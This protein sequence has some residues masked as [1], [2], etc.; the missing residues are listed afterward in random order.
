MRRVLLVFLALLIASLG[1]SIVSAQ[2]PNVQVFFDEYFGATHLE[3][4]PPDAP[5]TVTGYLYVVASNFGMWIS[6]FEYAIDYP[7]Q[8]LPVVDITGGLDIGTSALGIA[9]SWQYPINGYSPVLINK[10][11]ITFNCQLCYE[12]TNIPITVIPHPDT[13]F[14]RASRYPDYTLVNGVGMVSLICPTVPTEDTTWGTI[15]A[16][17]N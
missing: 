16:L 14:L 3:E 2:T 13:G 11:M 8:I 7:P 12:G 10:V 15:K 4:C 1:T 6:A 17:Y 9:T 5:G